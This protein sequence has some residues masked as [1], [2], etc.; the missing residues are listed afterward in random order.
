MASTV[1]TIT[2]LRVALRLAW[3]RSRVFWVVWVACLLLLMPATVTKYHD[4]VPPGSD[5]SMLD[6]LG[7]NPTM[8]AMLGVPFDL[9]SPGGFTMWRVGTFTAAAAAMMAALGVIRAT[10]AEEEEGRMELLR[11]GALGRHAPLA[12]AV[13]L[14]LIASSLLGALIAVSLI[15]L[16]TPAAGGIAAGIGIALT[17]AVFVGVGA[18][19]GQ[20]FESARTARY[21]ALGIVLGGL[22]LLRGAFDAIPGG[23][24]ANLNWTIPLE[25]AS[26][27]RPYAGERW[28]VFALPAALTA[29]LLVTAFRLESRRDH[30]A[31]LHTAQ[32]GRGEAAGWLGNADALAWRLHRGSVIGWTVSIVVSAL[33]IGSLGRSLESFVGSNPAVAEMLATMGGSGVLRDAF[34]MAMLGVLGTV[35]A[36]AVLTLLTRLNTEETHGRAEVI[37]ATDTGRLRFAAGHLIWAIAVPSALFV[38]LGA[39]MPVSQAIADGSWTMIAT[40]AGAAVALLPGLWLVA[41]LAMALIGWAPRLL[42]LIWALLGWTMFCTWIAALFDLPTWLVNLQPWG[43]LPKLPAQPMDWTAFLAQTALA[44]TLLGLGL[45]GYRRR[46]LGGC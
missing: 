29:G 9:S 35:L 39:L 1:T 3:R 46:D 22:Y 31:G 30:G 26:L 19:C 16:D 38:A 8:R 24:L 10:R 2:G 33:A 42:G 37:L 32:P 43:H 4:L 6:A 34:Y 44:V 21:W 12:A 17:A 36:L 28:W 5:T 45:V 13:L 41:G 20:L 11:A 27:A 18:V 14:S 7:D 25:W 15:S 23:R 40:F